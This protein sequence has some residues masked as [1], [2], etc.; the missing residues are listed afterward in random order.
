MT[1]P[2]IRP[3]TGSR[4]AQP[5]LTTGGGAGRGAS[6]GSRSAG[7]D[8]GGSSQALTALR[9]ETAGPWPPAATSVNICRSAYSP[10]LPMLKERTGRK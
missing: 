8:A 7:A 10:F 9:R 4:T 1:S 3:P 5:A 2:Q 6:A